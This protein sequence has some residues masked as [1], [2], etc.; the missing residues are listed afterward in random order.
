VAGAAGAV[1]EEMA[2]SLLRVAHKLRQGRPVKT[3]KTK[4]PTVVVAVVVVATAATVVLL[5][6]ETWAPVQ[7]IL[8]TVKMPIPM[9]VLQEVDLQ[10]RLASVVALHNQVM[11]ARRKFYLTYLVC[12]CTMAH[13]LNHRNSNG[14]T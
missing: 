14:S 8:D 12:L 3:A 6:Q 5:T 1:A 10:V 13:R 7:G 4:A 11:L 2:G 9:A